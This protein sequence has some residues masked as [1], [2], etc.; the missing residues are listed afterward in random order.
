MEEQFCEGAQQDRDGVPTRFRLGYHQPLRFAVIESHAR[1]SIE[2][3]LS[4]QLNTYAKLSET[5][6]MLS[7]SMARLSPELTRICR[8]SV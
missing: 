2:A 4:Y 8:L 5:G 3:E 7:T 1:H 6:Q